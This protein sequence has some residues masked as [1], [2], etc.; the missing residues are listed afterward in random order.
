MSKSRITNKRERIAIY[1]RY[2][3]EMQNEISLEDQESACRLAIANRSG[4]VIS[5]FVDSAKSGWSLDRD[6]FQE[7]RAAAERGKFDA[8]MM[9]KFDRLARA[10]DQVVMIK[11]LLRH[12]YGLKLYCVDGVSE[13]DD[14][15]PHTAMMEQMLAV[16]S[17]FYSRNL[18]TDT[19]RA[20]KQ[21]A[22]RGEFNGSRAPLGYVLVTLRNATLDRPAGLH[23]V[24]RQAVIVRRAYRLH[25]TGGYSDGQIAEWMNRQ[26]VVQKL[27]E[28]KQPI[29]K[30]MV[31]DMLQNRVYTGRVPYAET[32]YSGRLGEGKQSSRRRKEWYEG[33]HQAII[34][35]ELF[36]QSQQ[37]RARLLRT[38]KAPDQHRTYLLNDRVYCAKC[39]VSKPVELIDERYGKMRPFWHKDNQLGYYRCRAKE[40]GYEPCG[41]KFI[42]VEKLDEQVLSILSE[43]EIPEGF[44]ERVETAVRGRVENEAAL[45]RMEKLRETVNRIDFSWEKGF[46]T[47]DDY[48][49][50]RDQLQREIEALRPIDYDELIEAADLIENF[51]SYWDQCETVDNPE[52]ARKQ[53][54]DKIIECVLV[55]DGAVLA[56]VL[57]GDYGVVLEKDGRMG[58]QIAEELARKKATISYRSQN[59]SDGI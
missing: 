14:D 29:N 26:P 21:R 20:K 57:H 36:E 53:L 45:Q 43:L 33:K 41:Q 58:T 47:Q 19:K 40:R 51:Q 38:K 13:D 37:A 31:R 32:R 10:H 54:L 52:E 39:F 50:K 42:G 34:T 8:V 9:W 3:S 56:V 6:G 16:F 48:V 46:M 4:V 55:D 25:A 11:A 35:D 24:L 15:S 2:S 17:A 22:V 28:G 59:G 49:E 30:E 1:A 12:E 23:I 7:M 5:V 44:R 27:R 18:S